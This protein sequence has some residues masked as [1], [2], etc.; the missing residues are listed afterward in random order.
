VKTCNKCGLEKSLQEFGN[1][2][3]KRDGKQSYC[4]LCGQAYNKA[5][6]RKFPEK[7]REWNE[8]AKKVAQQY[9]WDYLK[10][11]P[12]AD[13]SEPDPIV[14]QFDHVRGEKR[15]N[16]GEASTSGYSVKMIQSEIDKC[17][18]RCANCHMRQTAS[19]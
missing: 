10:A 13:C 9:I 11:H 18:V 16:I 17:E 5:H 12:C 15:F 8:K 14:L 2:K 4:K 6:Y 1:N 3:N 19:W 7:R